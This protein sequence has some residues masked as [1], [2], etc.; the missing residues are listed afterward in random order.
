M[1]AQYSGGHDDGFAQVAIIGKFCPGILHRHYIQHFFVCRTS[2][3]MCRRVTVLFY[4]LCVSMKKSVDGE[5]G[6]ATEW[7]Y[8]RPMALPFQQWIDAAYRVTLKVQV[9]FDKKRQKGKS[10]NTGSGFGNSFSVQDWTI[11][12]LMFYILKNVFGYEKSAVQ[13][14]KKSLEQD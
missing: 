3:R 12:G 14:L 9:W 8:I 11:S 4:V 2:S 6:I 5:A 10:N 13:C 1:L 7:G